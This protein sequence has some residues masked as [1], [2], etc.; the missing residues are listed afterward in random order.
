MATTPG[1]PSMLVRSGNALIG[2]PVYGLSETCPGANVCAPGCTSG[3][4]IRAIRL[5]PAFNHI[6]SSPPFEETRVR[7][8]TGC[9]PAAIAAIEG[10]LSTIFHPFAG[11]DA[12][13]TSGGTSLRKRMEDRRE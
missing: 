13:R 9:C 8:N 11:N 6:T 10:R 7:K 2:A 12:V 4:E 5:L 3:C 1:R